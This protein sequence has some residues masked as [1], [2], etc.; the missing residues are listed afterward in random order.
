M[1]YPKE[2]LSITIEWHVSDVLEIAKQ[3]EHSITFEE[4][5]EILQRLKTAHDANFGITNDG[6]ADTISDYLKEKQ[7]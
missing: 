1:K 4:A 2:Q 3:I 7:A 6:I 5:L